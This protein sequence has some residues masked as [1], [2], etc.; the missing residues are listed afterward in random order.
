MITILL[1]KYI[2]LI[3]AL[4]LIQIQK[5]KDSLSGILKQFCPICQ[6]PPYPLSFPQQMA[7]II[8]KSLLN[9][10]FVQPQ[11][12][13]SSKNLPCHLNPFKVYSIAVDC[14]V[15]RMVKYHHESNMQAT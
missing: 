2:I 13:S 14:W 15:L 1:L 6:P 10:I 11:N 5:D 4:L 3:A 8:P 9:P 12:I 7:D